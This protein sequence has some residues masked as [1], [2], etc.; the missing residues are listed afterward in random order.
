MGG[1][2]FAAIDKSSART[3]HLS[4]S[5]NRDFFTTSRRNKDVRQSSLENSRHKRVSILSFRLDE[6]IIDYL[7]LQCCAPIRRHANEKKGD[8]IDW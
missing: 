4:S 1:A 5:K 3:S 7:C 8:D 2:V 6:P